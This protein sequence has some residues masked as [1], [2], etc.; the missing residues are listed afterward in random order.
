M[1]P[2]EYLKKARSLIGKPENWSQCYSARTAGGWQ[3]YINSN[4]ACSWCLNGAILKVSD[5]N[6]GRETGNDDDVINVVLSD[7]DYHKT[8]EALARETGITDI[9]VYDALSDFNDHYAT[10]HN[11]VTDLIDRTIEKMDATD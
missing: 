3:T 7:K 10:T 11:D 5:Y 4:D 6:D 9:C 1:Q 2:I 8:L